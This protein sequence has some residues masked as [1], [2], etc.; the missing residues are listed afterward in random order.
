VLVHH[1]RQQHLLFCVQQR[2]HSRTAAPLQ[3]K[4][5]PAARLLAVAAAAHAAAAAAL[6][7]LLLLLLEGLDQ[8]VAEALEHGQQH[9]LNDSTRGRGR[10]LLLL[11]LLLAAGVRRFRHCG[12]LRMLLLRALARLAATPR[13]ACG[14]VAAAQGL[15]RC[16]CCCRR[17]LALACHGVDI[18]HDDIATHLLLLLLLLLLLCGC[19]GRVWLLH[20]SAERQQHRWTHQQVVQQGRRLAPAL[21]SVGVQ[22][23][24][25][26]RLLLRQER[27]QE[28]R[29]QLHGQPVGQ[30]CKQGRNA[31][32]QAAVADDSASQQPHHISVFLAAAAAAAAAKEPVAGSPW[33]TTQ[34]QQ[35][36]LL[37]SRTELLPPL[38]LRL[39]NA[40]HLPVD[41]LY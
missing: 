12:L 32:L 9:L 2:R 22:Q 1:Q 16:C 8:A 21:H 7:L 29:S 10:H 11:L 39:S 27:R 40:L 26:Q 33:S 41:V 37:A 3:L 14:P 25:Q 23:E 30:R 35:R 24:R 6:K 15:R 18:N 20:S 19:V 34:R 31:L 28:Q 38:L 5:T 36:Q 17:R 4:G 13:V